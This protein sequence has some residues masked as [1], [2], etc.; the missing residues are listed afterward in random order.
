MNTELKKRA[1]ELD[2]DDTLEFMAENMEFATALCKDS[3]FLE[4]L[5]NEAT[6]GDV[7]GYITKKYKADIKRAVLWV[8]PDPIT[9]KNARTRIDDVIK[10]LLNMIIGDSD[11]FTSPEPEVEQTPSSSHSESTEANEQ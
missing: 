5:E 10:A 7:A 8:N 11:F 3:K 1:T 4:M 6:M 9:M 2:T